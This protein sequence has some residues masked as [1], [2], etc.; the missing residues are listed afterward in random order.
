MPLGLHSG[1]VVVVPYDQAWPALF[2][3][4][5]RRIRAALASELPLD[6]EHTGSTAVPGLAAKPIIDILA[7]Y[8]AGSAVEPYITALVGAG[9]SHRGE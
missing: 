6:F 3:A 7:G 1:T 4:E 8:P 5:E 9:Y 2:A